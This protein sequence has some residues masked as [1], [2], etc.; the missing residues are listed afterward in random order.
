MP[1]ADGIT[2]AIEPAFD[3]FQEKFW[4]AAGSPKGRGQ[5]AEINPAESHL[6]TIILKILQIPLLRLAAALNLFRQ[7]ARWNISNSGVVF[8]SPY[9]WMVSG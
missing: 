4:T 8:S 2:L 9:A 7:I 1:F 3:K 6:E 5:Q